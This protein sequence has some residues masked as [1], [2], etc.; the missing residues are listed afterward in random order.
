MEP[1]SPSIL[2]IIAVGVHPLLKTDCIMVFSL[3]PS[4]SVVPS[5]PRNFNVD[6]V[7]IAKI[8][9]SGDSTST[10]LIRIVQYC[11]LPPLRCFR[12]VGF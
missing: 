3:S 1:G 12:V 5:D 9:V 4:A 11:K 8:L 7:R 6:N 2:A 10:M